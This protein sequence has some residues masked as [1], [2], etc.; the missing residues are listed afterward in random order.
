MKVSRVDFSLLQKNK[1]KKKMK[2]TYMKNKKKHVTKQH[3]N[4]TFTAKLFVYSTF[5]IE[6][7]QSNSL[8]VFAKGQSVLT[9]WKNEG[10]L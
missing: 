2:R 9:E 3:Q 4:I 6:Q 10:R 7:L 8:N 1:T 5:I